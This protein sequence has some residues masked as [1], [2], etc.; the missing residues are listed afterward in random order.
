L[1]PRTVYVSP[2]SKVSAA[3]ATAAHS[4][5]TTRA[6]IQ[7]FF[8][9]I[10]LQGFVQQHGCRNGSKNGSDLFDLSPYQDHRHFAQVPKVKSVFLIFEKVSMF[11]AVRPEPFLAL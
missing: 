9:I 8:N 5:I 1:L 11:S 4:V 3:I 6:G 10:A 7:S 2:I